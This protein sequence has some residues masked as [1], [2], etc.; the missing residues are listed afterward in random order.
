[1]YYLIIEGVGLQGGTGTECNECLSNA[2][3]DCV[4][5]CEVICLKCCELVRTECENGYL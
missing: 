5:T 3:K 4:K 1:M 2:C